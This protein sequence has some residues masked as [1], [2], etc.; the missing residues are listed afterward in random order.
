LNELSAIHTGIGRHPAIL[1]KGNPLKQ[2]SEAPL[3][4]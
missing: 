4:R 3:K 1:R 2:E